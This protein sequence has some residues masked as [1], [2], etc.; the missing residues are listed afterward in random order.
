MNLHEA[1]MNPFQSPQPNDYE[2]TV[3]RELL[4]LSREIMESKRYK[5]LNEKKQAAEDLLSQTLA[6]YRTWLEF[7][8]T[9]SLEVPASSSQS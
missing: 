6:H 8:P 2:K 5:S 7:T 3:A 9:T 4:W 1:L